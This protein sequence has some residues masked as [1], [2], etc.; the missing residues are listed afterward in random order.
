M[1]PDCQDLRAASKKIKDNFVPNI[2][3]KQDKNQLLFM[4]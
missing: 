3:V 1:E 4:Q 2:S